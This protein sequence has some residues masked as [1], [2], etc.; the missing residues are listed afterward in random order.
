MRVRGMGWRCIDFRGGSLRE[1][2]VGRAA[3]DGRVLAETAEKEKNSDPGHRYWK[4]EMRNNGHRLSAGGFGPFGGLGKGL[5]AE[6]RALGKQA[7]EEG[8]GPS[9]EAV[10]S[11][12]CAAASLLIVSAAARGAQRLRGAG[13]LPKPTAAASRWA[14][15][16]REVGLTS[17]EDAARKRAVGRLPSL[18]DWPWARVGLLRAM[19]EG[20]QGGKARGRS[21]GRKREGGAGERD[22][23]RREGA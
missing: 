17:A 22:G 9:V 3:E 11:T 23:E 6:L 10:G 4:D 1:D 16:R 15:T 18:V 5:A 12:I 21:G 7:D 8:T 19:A 13:I 2:L 20:A 14:D